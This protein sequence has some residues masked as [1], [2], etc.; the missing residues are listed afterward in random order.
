MRYVYSGFGETRLTSRAKSS[1]MTVQKTTPP[2][3]E[4]TPW[5]K[6]PWVI[7]GG[8]AALLMIGGTIYLVTRK[9]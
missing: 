2:P 8:A 7:G 6:S 3:S 9:G 5:Y 1:T 4:S